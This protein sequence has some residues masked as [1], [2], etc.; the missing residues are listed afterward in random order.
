MGAIGFTRFASL[1]LVFEA[2]VGEEHLFAGG[3][4]KLCATIGTLQNPIMVFHTLLRTRTG[5]GQAAYLPGNATARA[6]I[7]LAARL[8]V[9]HCL[10]IFECYSR[11][12]LLTP[13]FFPET[14]TRE[15]L[16][17]TALLPRLH[18][19]AVLFDLLDDVF[20]L[21][22]PLE[23]AESVFQRFALLNNYF[24]HAYSPPFLFVR[25]N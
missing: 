22:F 21:H 13:L 25:L 12:I 4:N 17:C 14:F 20:R 19:V 2:F 5:R 15:S 7:F 18:V 1:R 6:A 11:L 23:A 16:F 10:E 3:E 9:F 24:C 8:G